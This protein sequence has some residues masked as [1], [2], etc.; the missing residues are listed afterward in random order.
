MDLA[1]IFTLLFM[2]IT[3]TYS[4]ETGLLTHIIRMRSKNYVSQHGYIFQ[5]QYINLNIGN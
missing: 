1:Y 2:Y 4:L 5:I 3:Y